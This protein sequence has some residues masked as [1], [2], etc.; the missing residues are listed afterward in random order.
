M[1]ELLSETATTLA[2][3]RQVSSGPKDRIGSPSQRFTAQFDAN[4]VPIPEQREPL[5]HFA[6]I[7]DA[8]MIDM[9]LN[10]LEKVSDE[11]VHEL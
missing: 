6:K 7:E 2:D 9:P 10:V 1:N 8:L 11:S 5:T 3:S 4:A